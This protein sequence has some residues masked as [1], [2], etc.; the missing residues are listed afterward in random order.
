MSKDYITFYKTCRER[1]GIKQEEA[2]AEL[3]VSCRTLSDYE[4]SKARVPDDIVDSM[5][6]LYKSPLLAWWHIKNN[7][8]LGKYLPDV[9][10][11]N[12]DIEMV[13][14]GILAKDKLSLSIDG[15]KDI[16]S[17]GL[18][19]EREENLCDTYMDDVKIVNNW[20]TSMIFRYD[21]RKKAK[22][23]SRF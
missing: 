6:I 5:A 20:L 19:D 13:F 16:M 1:A 14:Q 12:T 3:N 4:N 15:L 18:I 8:V 22:K 10:T 23:E 11:L 17:D 2:A 9:S 7:S 21:E